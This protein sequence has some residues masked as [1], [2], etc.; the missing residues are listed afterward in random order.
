MS[1]EYKQR[2]N[3]YLEEA[4]NVEELPENVSEFVSE[5]IDLVPSRDAPYLF[6]I[7]KKYEATLDYIE[8]PY[9]DIENKYGV[10]PGDVR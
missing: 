1:S 2:A 10:Y 6:E 9:L 5:L 4:L 7:I 3:E 8:A